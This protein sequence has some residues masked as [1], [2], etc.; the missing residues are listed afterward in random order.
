MQKPPLQIGLKG[1]FVG[2]TAAAMLLAGLVA[3]EP[4]LQ[5]VAI[6]SILWLVWAALLVAFAYAISVIAYHVIRVFAWLRS[7]SRRGSRNRPMD[8]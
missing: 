4:G 3:S 2:M 5:L 7:K 1:M 8:A 6:M